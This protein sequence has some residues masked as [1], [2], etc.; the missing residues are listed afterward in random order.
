MFNLSSRMKRPTSLILLAALATVSAAALPTPAS[1]AKISAVLGACKRTAGCDSWSDG[2][3]WAIGCG[4]HG[5]FE[6]DKGNCHA[7]ARSVV[8]TKKSEAGVRGSVDN[9]SSTGHTTSSKPT[10]N[11]GETAPVKFGA[12][13]TNPGTT[14]MRMGG[15]H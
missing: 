4:P 3:G 6:C 11:R 1:A 10:V 7:I 12:S 13:V 14:K 9:V 5:C 2:K 15:K 8:E